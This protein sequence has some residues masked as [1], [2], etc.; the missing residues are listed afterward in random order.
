MNTTKLPRIALYVLALLFLVLSFVILKE[1]SF[2]LIP[3]TFAALLAMLMLPLNRLLEKWRFPRVLAIVISLLVI[4]VILGGIITLISVQVVSFM[5]DLPTIEQQLRDKFT[6]LQAFVQQV[7]G[8]T[9]EKQM[10]FIDKESSSIMS[11]ADKWGAGI[12]MTTG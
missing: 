5:K 2:Y 3:A 4:L 6:E 1:L 9:V 12:L 7:S 11:S 8:F 10:D